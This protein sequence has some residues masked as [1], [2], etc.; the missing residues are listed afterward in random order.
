MKYKFRIVLAVVLVVISGSL[1][2]LN[3]NIFY[4]PNSNNITLNLPT[5]ENKTDINAYKTTDEIE[6]F[7]TENVDQSWWEKIT[8]FFSNDEL[9]LDM[10]NDRIDILNTSYKEFTDA[11]LI[12][13]FGVSATKGT[14]EVEV[15][16]KSEKKTENTISVTFTTNSGSN[17]ELSA[18]GLINIVYNQKPIIEIKNRKVTIRKSKIEKLNDEDLIKLIIKESGAKATDK[19]DKNSEISM[20]VDLSNLERSIPGEYKL[21][22]IASDTDNQKSDASVIIKIK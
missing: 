5:F 2:I 11:E 17:P 16:V 19:E 14:K 4:N 15:T 13:L 21:K 18:N 8:S 1:V 7:Q 22:V 9:S 10:E 12:E 20:T 3:P 6:T